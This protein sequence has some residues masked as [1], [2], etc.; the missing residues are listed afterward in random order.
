MFLELTL[1]LEHIRWAAR[2]ARSVLRPRSVSP[3]ALMA[4]HA[5]RVEQRPLGVVGVIGPWNYPLF[6]PN[7]S[8]AYALAGCGPGWT[9]GR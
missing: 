1:T 3:G 8:I 7:G 2:H 9:T 6:T 4:N 5:A